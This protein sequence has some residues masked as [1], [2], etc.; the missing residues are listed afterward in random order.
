MKVM[1]GFGEEEAR[2]WRR[3]GGEVDGDLREDEGSELGTYYVL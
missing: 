2:V 3:G 1:M